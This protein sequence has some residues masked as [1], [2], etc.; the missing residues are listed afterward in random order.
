MNA[1]A[2]VVVPPTPIQGNQQNGNGVA[3]VAP[4]DNN[5]MFV[6]NSMMG[7]MKEQQRRND[8]QM[9]EQQRRNDAQM[10]EERRIN[11]AQ[12]MEQRNQFQTMQHSI[13]ENQRITSK[14]VDLLAGMRIEISDLG[15]KV[16]GLQAGHAALKTG[17]ATLESYYS[18][19]KSGQDDNKEKIDFIMKSIKKKRKDFRYSSGDSPDS[20]G[21][22][23][24]STITSSHCEIILESYLTLSSSSSSSS[25]LFVTVNDDDDD[26]SVSDSLGRRLLSVNLKSY[27]SPQQEI[28]STPERATAAGARR[29][30][31][32]Q[33]EENVSDNEKSNDSWKLDDEDGVDVAED[34]SQ[35]ESDDEST[36][37][38]CDDCR[39]QQAQTFC[40]DKN[41]RRY[42]RP[43][44]RT[45]F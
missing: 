26:E 28:L 10:M 19:L 22:S 43:T 5:L 16:S 9:M 27:E 38:E 3:G 17:H 32:D 6:V 24:K 44:G 7:Q 2:V 20:E 37:T 13:D 30:S 41:C 11:N 34:E 39:D 42:F 33:S 21:T 31:D 29:A 1:N 40:S 15:D 18:E 25:F 12:M 35:M 36:L 8:A 23:G 4:P 14:N 45:L